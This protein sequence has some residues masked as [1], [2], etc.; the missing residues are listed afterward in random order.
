MARVWLE[1]GCKESVE[2]MAELNE[3]LILAIRGTVTEYD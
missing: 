2:E 3:Q 1:R